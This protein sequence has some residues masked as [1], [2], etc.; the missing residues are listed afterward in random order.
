MGSNSSIESLL[1][2]L[3]TLLKLGPLIKGRGLSLSLSDFFVPVLVS[4]RVHVLLSGIFQTLLLS[5]GLS[6]CS[7]LVP[8][9][10][11]FFLGAS[12]FPDLDLLRMLLAVSPGVKTLRLF[13]CQHHVFGVSAG[14]PVPSELSLVCHLKTCLLRTCRKVMPSCN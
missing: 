10:L 8:P 5:S 13:R 12:I 11:P 9:G 2:S 6:L 1:Y 14:P 7:L 4:L 3:H